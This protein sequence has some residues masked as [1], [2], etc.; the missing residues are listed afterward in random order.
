MLAYFPQQP[1]PANIGGML[2]AVGINLHKTGIVFNS[3]VIFWHPQN[4]SGAT[5]SREDGNPT[6]QSNGKHAVS[7]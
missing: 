2:E 6:A 1:F 4:K 7:Q 3:K 5:T